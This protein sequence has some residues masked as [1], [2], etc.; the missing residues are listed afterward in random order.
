MH[1]L[2]VNLFYNNCSH[3]T[4]SY[5]QCNKIVQRNIRNYTSFVR[6]NDDNIRQGKASTVCNY[7][8]LYSG[9]KGISS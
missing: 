9:T 7:G 4:S 5:T 3:V 8:Q 2:S 6:T 1:F